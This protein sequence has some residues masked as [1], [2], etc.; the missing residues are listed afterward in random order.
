MARKP[1][2][3]RRPRVARPVPPPIE[4]PDPAR[5]EVAIFLPDKAD[6]DAEL[7]RLVDA[8]VRELALE[9][10]ANPDE[11]LKVKWLLVE[12]D[13][14]K[15]RGPQ[16]L[17]VRDYLAV[18]ARIRAGQPVGLSCQLEGIHPDTWRTAD[19]RYRE[20]WGDAQAPRRKPGRKKKYPTD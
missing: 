15:P 8:A 12:I 19:N 6:A 10:G 5:E 16:G 7:E 3:P 18:A 14:R 4:V 2:R 9:V 13:E 20:F 11:L 17:S 1:G